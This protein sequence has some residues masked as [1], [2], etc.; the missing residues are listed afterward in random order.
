MRLNKRVEALE[1]VQPDT[2]RG[3]PFL[4]AEG[5][6]LEDALAD[7]ALTLDDKPLFAIRL[8]GVHPGETE[9]RPDPV[10]EREKVLLR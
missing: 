5:Q 6:P 1:A 2:D 7:A 9:P 4:W 8:V 10:Y 3:H